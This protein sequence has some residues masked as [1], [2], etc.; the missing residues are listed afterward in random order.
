MKVLFYHHLPLPVK[1]YGGTER[2]MFWHMKELVRLGHE[3]TLIGHPDSEVE[4]FGIK[5]VPVQ[6]DLIRESWEQ[7][8]PTGI[9]IV[10]LQFSYVVANLPTIST[11]H[12]NGQSQIF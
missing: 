6:A 5:L 3:V 12:G 8:I 10:H 7:F 9:D 2:I 1:K 11:V 4:K